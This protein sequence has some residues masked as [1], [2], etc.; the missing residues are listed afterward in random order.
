VQYLDHI[1]IYHPRIALFATVLGALVFN[2][3]ADTLT[4]K[5]GDTYSGVLVAAKAGKLSF[6]TKLVGKIVVPIDEVQ[7]VSTAN[8]VV[9]AME[10]DRRLPGRLRSRDGSIFVVGQGG[11]ETWR[12]VEMA[13]VQ[14]ITATAASASDDSPTLRPPAE[15]DTHGSASAGYLSRSGEVSFSGP[16]VE[17]E[18]GA[19]G[20]RGSLTGRIQAEYVGDELKIDR[21]A[22]AEVR[23]RGATQRKW[24]PEFSVEFERNRNKALKLRTDFSAALAASLFQGDEQ[25]LEVGAGIGVALEKF[26]ADPLRQDEGGFA[27]PRHHESP[28]RDTDLNLDLRLNYR[29]SLYRGSYIEE[30]LSIR[31]SLTDFGEVRSRWESSLYFPVT[32]MMEFKLKFQLDYENDLPYQDVDELETGVEASIKYSF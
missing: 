17:I 23:V 21:F 7:A 15:I 28:Q 5:D 27:A 24:S 30:I 1:S 12:A 13:E 29:R 31:P 9:V 26:D 18:L 16:A 6:R 8:L 22:E 3:G 10:D 2:A 32:K 20:E 19:S 4:L 14:T 25:S 11:E